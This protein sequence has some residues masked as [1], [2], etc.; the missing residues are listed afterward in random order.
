MWV[1]LVGLVVGFG[2]VSWFSPLRSR[3]SDAYGG[4]PVALEFGLDFVEPFGDDGQD[5]LA[6][7]VRVVGFDDE[8]VSKVGDFFRECLKPVVYEASL[9]FFF[10]GCGFHYLT[11]LLFM[12]SCWRTW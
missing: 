5:V 10:D 1:V 8:D 4:L 11:W 12:L 3:D 7:A 6:R 2:F 9:A